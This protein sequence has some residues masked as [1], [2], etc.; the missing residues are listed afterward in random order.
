[1]PSIREAAR[2]W[3][4][5]YYSADRRLALGEV[6]PEEGVPYV[7]SIDVIAPKPKPQ[8][9]L[10]RRDHLHDFHGA[11]FKVGIYSDTHIGSKYEATKE[12]K[13]FYRLCR[14]EG[15]T[16]LYHAGDVTAGNGVYR[17][18]IFEL[19]DGCIGAQAQVERAVEDFLDA[20]LD[21]YF[22]I[23]N[24][25]AKWWMAHGFDVGKQIEIA[26]AASGT[27]HTIQCVGQ[28]NARILIGE[29]PLCCILDLIHPMGGTAYAISYRAQK[30]AESY[31]GGDK[32]HIVAIGH[33]HKA[34]ELPQ[35][36][37]IVAIQPGCFEWQTPFMRQKAI[38]AHVGGC[39][40]E[41]WMERVNGR[42]S[43]SRLRVEWA[44][45]YAPT[46]GV[47]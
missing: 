13:A 5:S 18:Q 7:S 9:N 40:V 1:M 28:G 43:L 20:D 8:V 45:F 46:T 15:V 30:I 47:G 6:P 2:R 33:F 38:E 34:E 22:I 11:H 44:K 42:A 3:R 36:R 29:K 14:E 12:R 25:D 41:G 17:G 31:T 35:L 32:P 4:C 19:M 16:T 26:A 23:G 39:I 27:D 21:I 24:H 10:E 37:N